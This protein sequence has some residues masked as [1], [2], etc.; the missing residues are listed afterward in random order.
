MFLNSRDRCKIE[1][2]QGWVILLV[3]VYVKIFEYIIHQKLF[4]AGVKT[5]KQYFNNIICNLERNQ[6]LKFGL[7]SNV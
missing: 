3:V 4:P 2:I 1:H 6:K 7:P 5:I